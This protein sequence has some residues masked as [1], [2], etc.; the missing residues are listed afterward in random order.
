MS[1]PVISVNTSYSSCQSCGKLYDEVRIL[2]NDLSLAEAK[3]RAVTQ[4]LDSLR[5]HLKKYTAPERARTYYQTHKDE[6]K[7][8]PEYKKQRSEINKRA[9]QKRK[10]KENDT[11]SY[12][13]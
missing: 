10:Q 12:I 5:D 8:D 7:Q 1:T 13:T 11:V 6:L 9:Y 4:E 2:S 3:L